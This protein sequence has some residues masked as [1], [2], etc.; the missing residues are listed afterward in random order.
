MRQTSKSTEEGRTMKRSSLYHRKYTPAST[1]S[2]WCVYKSVDFVGV[3]FGR[4][5]NTLGTFVA[6]AAVARGPFA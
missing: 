4:R 6:S 5:S 1:E 2:V 3:C